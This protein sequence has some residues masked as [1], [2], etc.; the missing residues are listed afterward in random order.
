MGYGCREDGLGCGCGGRIGYR[1]GA[2]GVD[3]FGYAYI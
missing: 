2:D 1:C 3:G